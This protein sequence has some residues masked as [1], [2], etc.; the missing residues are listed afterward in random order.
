MNK[1][2]QKKGISKVSLGLI[3]KNAK[4]GIM[5]NARVNQAEAIVQLIHHHIKLPLL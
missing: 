4:K 3:P 2:K 5:E 1:Q